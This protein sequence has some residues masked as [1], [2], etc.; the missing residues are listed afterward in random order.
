MSSRKILQK[1]YSL[2]SGTPVVEFE[3]EIPMQCPGGLTQYDAW[4][5]CKYM[6]KILIAPIGGFHYQKISPFCQTFYG[7]KLDV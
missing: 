3:M 4:Y 7:L 6:G 2:N 5:L 1:H